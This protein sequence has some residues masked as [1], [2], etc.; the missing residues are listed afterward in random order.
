MNKSEEFRTAILNA[1]VGRAKH[2]AHFGEKAFSLF[3]RPAHFRP[4]VRVYPN[5]VEAFERFNDTVARRF[6]FGDE[7]AEHFVPDD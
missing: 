1:N 2:A 3:H 5:G 6:G 4:G 7:S